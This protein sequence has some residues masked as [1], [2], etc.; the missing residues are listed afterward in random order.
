MH[1]KP[2]NVVTD[3]GPVF[4]GEFEDVGKRAGIPIDKPA[5]DPR[6]R[7]TIESFFRYLRRACRYF[8]G[9]TFSNVV[10]KSDYDSEKM[11]TLTVEEFRK[12]IIKFIVDIYHHRPHRGLEYFT[13]FHAWEKAVETHGFPGN[14]TPAQRLAGFGISEKG[15]RLDNQGVLYVGIS[16]ASTDLG[17]LLMKL[18]IGAKVDIV[19]DPE[20]LGSIFVYVPEL[21]RDHM[22]AVAPM[23][24]HGEFLKVPAVDRRFQGTKLADKFMRSEQVRKEAEEAAKKGQPF[25]IAAH[26]ALSDL[27][28]K[29]A[30][31][32]GLPT[33][34]MTREVYERARAAFDR[35]AR[36]S[37][38]DPVFPEDASPSDEES[39]G[40]PV[41]KSKQNRTIKPNGKTPRPKNSRPGPGVPPKS[42]PGPPPPP[43]RNRSIYDGDD[44]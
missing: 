7:G 1:G 19:V 12:V 16:Y 15:V 35:E 2:D 20:D 29:A 21:W 41:A 27:A 3:G 4:K 18:G 26:T 44:E 11:A 39:L 40:T 5:P 43:K 17:A 30:D 32:A 38:G 24:M 14:I 34:Q 22:E 31:R 33:Q 13:P 6:Q 36:Q 23:K 10:E 42:D 28:R 25:R 37:T 8:D 9:R